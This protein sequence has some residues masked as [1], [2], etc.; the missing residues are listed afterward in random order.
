MPKFG[1]SGELEFGGWLRKKSYM[2][3]PRIFFHPPPPQE[4]LA[5][6]HAEENIA[7]E[8]HGVTEGQAQ[9]VPQGQK[10]AG[11]VRTAHRG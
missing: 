11:L 7:R 5:E 1:S 3:F 2:L 10:A 6:D 4:V 8:I 9:R